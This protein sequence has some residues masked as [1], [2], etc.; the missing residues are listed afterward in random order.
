MQP[1]TRQA[2]RSRATLAALYALA[3]L[4]VHGLHA[5]HGVSSDEHS[6]PTACCEG[7]GLHKT[8]HTNACDLGGHP[9]AC[10]ACQF[11]AQAGI[12]PL[13]SPWLPRPS[14]ARAEPSATAVEACSLPSPI[15]NRGP[16]RV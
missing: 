2:D 11:L 6:R 10:P 14:T 16:P 4:L 13:R 5:D 12:E 1:R 3:M 8:P 7:A 15:S 9:D